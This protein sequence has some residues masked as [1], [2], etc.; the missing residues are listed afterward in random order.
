MKLASHTITRSTIRFHYYTRY[1]TVSRVEQ[2]LF[3]SL[4]L[5]HHWEVGV[6][7]PTLLPPRE[8][9]LQASWLLLD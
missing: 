3:S 4:A 2:V 8:V 5:N 9:P 6:L 1:L 7:N